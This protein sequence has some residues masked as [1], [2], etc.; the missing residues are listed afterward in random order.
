MLL[1]APDLLHLSAEGNHVYADAIY[2]YVEAAVERTA[3]A[4]SDI[5]AQL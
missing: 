2:P 3:A 4:N 5:E 1:P